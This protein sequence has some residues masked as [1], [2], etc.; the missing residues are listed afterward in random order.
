MAI[1]SRLAQAAAGALGLLAVSPGLAA[2]PAAD[3]FYERAVMTAADGDCRLFAPDVATALSAAKAQARGAALR[4]GDDAASLAAAEA[5][6]SAAV[7]AA[8]CGSADI[9]KAAQAVRTAFAGYARLDHMDFP[10]EFA[11]W[12]AARPLS[13]PEPQWRV[14]Q[15]DRFGWDVMLFGLVGRGADRP[16]TAVADF[17]DGAQPYAARLVVRDASVTSGPFLDAREADIA[18]HIPIDGRLPPREQTRVFAA[19]EMAPAETTLLA[20][21]MPG[22]WAF[23]F[24]A[25][26]TDALAGLDPRESV[27]VEFLFA[28]EGGETVRTAYV[29]VGDFA[30]AQAFQS[31]AQQ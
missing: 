18:G 8:G 24:P 13:T 12:T 25:A 5:R 10:G 15:R 30:A 17:A 31:I 3:V 19:A 1:W 28:G 4:S 9:A 27:A 2:T 14:S 20:P 11:A 26:A 7:A 16:L 6:A 29:E 21:D 23:T 22:A